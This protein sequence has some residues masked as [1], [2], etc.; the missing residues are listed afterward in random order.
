MPKLII[1]IEI[2]NKVLALA[3]KPVLAMQLNQLKKTNPAI[4]SVNSRIED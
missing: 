4:L 2:E 1:E 3:I